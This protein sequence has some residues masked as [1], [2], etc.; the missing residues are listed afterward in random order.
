MNF[1]NFVLP[2]SPQS[3]LN[4]MFTNGYKKSVETCHAHHVIG[5]AKH[6]QGNEQKN[7]YPTLFVYLDKVQRGLYAYNH[8]QKQNGRIS[9]FILPCKIWRFYN[10][11]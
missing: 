11:G 7:K 3:Q 10:I 2:I 8:I 6:H 5:I 1:D 4:N 9:I